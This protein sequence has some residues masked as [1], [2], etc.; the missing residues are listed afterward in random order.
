MQTTLQEQQA[1]ESFA[2][3]RDLLMK[4]VSTLTK[5]KDKLNLEVK[6]LLDSITSTRQELDTIN[7]LIK[8]QLKG[9]GAVSEKVRATIDALKK[10]VEYIRK[11]KDAIT[12]ELAERTNFLRDTSESVER[13]ANEVKQ[14]ENALKGVYIDI[15]NSATWMKE[16]VVEIQQIVFATRENSKK[17][18]EDFVKYE[19]E[20]ADRIAYLDKKEALILARET[21]VDDKYRAYITKVTEGIE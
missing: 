16:A 1:L 6:V 20:I 3:Q 4:E 19:K 18:T 10:D 5:E 9:E 15:H 8:A 12:L 2:E 11:E 21:A 17:F 7:E 14:T 13:I